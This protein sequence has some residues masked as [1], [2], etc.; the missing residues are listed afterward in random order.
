M[1]VESLMQC[2]SQRAIVLETIASVAEELNSTVSSLSDATPLLESGLDSLGW[3]IV[4][5]RLEERLGRDP[6]S[7]TEEVPFPVTIGN[8]IRAYDEGQ[9]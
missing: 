4:V 8:F 3:A 5:A 2:M 6:F 9:E 1:D 7:R